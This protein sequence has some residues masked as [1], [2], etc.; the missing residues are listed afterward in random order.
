QGIFAAVAAEVGC[1]VKGEGAL[2]A[3]RDQ[4]E[5]AAVT[6]F[7]RHEPVQRRHVLDV[8][9]LDELQG[10]DANKILHGVGLRRQRRHAAAHFATTALNTDQK[11][12]IRVATSGDYVE[13]ARLLENHARQLFEQG[14]TRE[15]GPHVEQLGRDDLVSQDA[16]EDHLRACVSV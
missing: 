14:I 10:R 15:G 3:V 11:V 12:Y 7:L 2:A 9:R 13:E 16:G 1:G 5:L 8:V 6:P 4:P